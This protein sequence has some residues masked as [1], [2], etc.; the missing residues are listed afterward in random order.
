MLSSLLLILTS[1]CFSSPLSRLVVFSSF[2]RFLFSPSLRW[3]S[4]L[5]PLVA[6]SLLSL[7]MS[8]LFLSFLYPFDLFSFL[9]PLSLFSHVPL[10]FSYF[11]SLSPCASAHTILVNL[12]LS[13]SPLFSLLYSSHPPSNP[14]LF[15][16][17]LSFISPSLSLFFLLSPKCSQFSVLP[18]S[19]LFF[20]LNIYS[21]L[22]IS[23]FLPFLLTIY[24]TIYYF[25]PFVLHFPT[26]D[27]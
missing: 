2:P 18:I 6:F 26:S 17:V 11:T 10:L 23:I 7:F 4:V 27:G 12:F 8:V 15:H 22:N 20:Y 25:F 5:F 9:S 24:H 16:C 3:P 13:S 21:I 19:R 1:C 14:L